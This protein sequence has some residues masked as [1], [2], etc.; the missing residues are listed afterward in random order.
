MSKEYNIQDLL[1]REVFVKETK[2]GVIVGERH[3]PNE[4]RVASMRL[5]VLPEIAEEYM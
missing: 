5:E 1:Q 4:S 3:H 2:V